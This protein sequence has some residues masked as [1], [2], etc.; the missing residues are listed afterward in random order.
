M[1]LGFCVISSVLTVSRAHY[2]CRWSV[3]TS[4]CSGGFSRYWRWQ[5]MPSDSR[6]W[7]EKVSKEWGTVLILGEVGGNK[8]VKEH[9]R[10]TD[11]K[12]LVKF[13]QNWSKQ[14]IQHYSL[15]YTRFMPFGVNIGPA[16]ERFCKCSTGLRWMVSFRCREGVPHTCCGGWVSPRASL[17]ISEVENSPVPARYIT[18]IPWMFFR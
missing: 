18:M 2:V 5:P 17:Y 11:H 15:I 3:Q 16:M 9:K 12:M 7:T 13:W 8:C 14:K 4:F 6:L 1:L 10:D